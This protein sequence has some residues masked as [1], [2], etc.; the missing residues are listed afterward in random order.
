MSMIFPQFS[1]IFNTILFSLFSYLLIDQFNS[2]A[3]SSPFI[4]MFMKD[5]Q[6]DRHKESRRNPS[7]SAT[8]TTVSTW[9]HHPEKL[10]TEA[11]CYEASVSHSCSFRLFMYN[12]CI[13]TYAKNNICKRRRFARYRALSKV[14]TK[15]HSYLYCS[16]DK[17]NL[18]KFMCCLIS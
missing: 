12:T 2:F 7:Q 15:L 14:H 11:C 9:H 4:G 13:S 3:L 1:V 10:I 8:Y 16:F 17:F 6:T 18:K 5:R